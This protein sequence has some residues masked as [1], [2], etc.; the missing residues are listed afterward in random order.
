MGA[1]ATGPRT[2]VNPDH[3]GERTALNKVGCDLDLI[4]TTS[5]QRWGLSVV[6]SSGAMALLTMKHW[7]ASS[8]A[9]L[10]GL[11]LACGGG[12]P[13]PRDQLTES[14]AAVR[15]A[16]VAG[17]QN[18]PQAALHLKRAREQIDAG[19]GLI[20]E[21]ENER[22]EWMLRRAR[23]D[24][25]LAMSLATEDAQ[26]KKAAEVKEELDQLKQSMRRGKP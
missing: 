20:Q 8:S 6:G 25:D 14:E 16:E 18:T 17:A 26:R 10:T 11:L 5:R 7:S 23:A 9:A 1:S 19:K 15:A 4:D 24:A 13:E 12:Y 21:G 22:A 3:S 2:V